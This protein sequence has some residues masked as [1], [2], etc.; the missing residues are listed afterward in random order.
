MQADL[1]VRQVYNFYVKNCSKNQ[2]LAYKPM[3]KKA[4]KNLVN[5][6]STLFLLYS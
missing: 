4:I 3:L 5:K 6:N 2:K 1:C